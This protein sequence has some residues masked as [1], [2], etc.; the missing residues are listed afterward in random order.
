MRYSKFLKYWYTYYGGEAAIR[1]DGWVDLLWNRKDRAGLIFPLGSLNPTVDVGRATL[2]LYVTDP[3][4]SGGQVYPI[5]TRWNEEM[6]GRFDSSLAAMLTSDSIATLGPVTAGSWVEIDVT[7]AVRAHASGGKIGFGILSTVA[8]EVGYASKEHPGSLAPELRIWGS[9]SRDLFVIGDSYAAFAAGRCRDLRSDSDTEIDSITNPLTGETTTCRHWRVLPSRGLLGILGYWRW[10]LYQGYGSMDLALR[11]DDHGLG[12]VS[13]HPYA[14]AGSTAYAWAS[15]SNATVDRLCTNDGSPIDISGNPLVGGIAIASLLYWYDC[16]ALL[17]RVLQQIS[18]SANPIVWLQL[19]GNDL[20]LRLST[21]QDYDSPDDGSNWDSFFSEYE[22][23]IRSL[24]NRINAASQ[25][26][27]TII[28]PSYAPLPG[29]SD[30]ESCHASNPEVDPV[31]W[32]NPEA[33]WSTA[34]ATEQA[35][36]VA[37]L[38]ELAGTG[39][40]TESV[41]GFA[42]VIAGIAA[43][44]PNVEYVDMRQFSAAYQ[45]PDC[46]H[47]TMESFDFYVR[48]V[49]HRVFD[50]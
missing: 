26:T 31:H 41:P 22:E 7:D 5:A 37:K 2:R 10:N 44:Y 34:T 6:S 4:S 3:S 29:R 43:D 11:N 49:L 13:V 1:A 28:L 9:E 32:L 40:Q 45:P 21:G 23:G 16:P 42:G 24:I 48:E 14:V 27:A 8:D 47:P 20:H 39:N 19:G 17:G 35:A 33:D 50:Q 36:A 46:F 38:D 12:P 18:D 15:T 30:W 25:G